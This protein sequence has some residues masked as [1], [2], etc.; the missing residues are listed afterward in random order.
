MPSWRFKI[1]WGHFATK[2]GMKMWGS[3]LRVHSRIVSLGTLHIR[4]TPRKV[5]RSTCKIVCAR[6]S[7]HNI[8]LIRMLLSHHN[9]WVVEG[10]A[11]LTYNIITVKALGGRETVND[12]N[13]VL[14]RRSNHKIKKTKSAKVR[15]WPR[16]YF[17]KISLQQLQIKVQKVI[18]VVIQ[19]PLLKIEKMIKSFNSLTT[20]RM[21]IPNGKMTKFKM[22][23]FSSRWSKWCY[24]WTRESYSSP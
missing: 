8:L 24:L 9:T 19:F 16:I 11:A 22:E 1:T 15:E 21:I 23:V 13:S 17:L 2:N 20:R 4:S 5:K 6:P 14:N 12:A 7:I 10:P 3:Y 18:N